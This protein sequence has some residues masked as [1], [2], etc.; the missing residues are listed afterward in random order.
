VCSSD[1]HDLPFV[2]RRFLAS[3]V[4]PD[5]WRVATDYQRLQRNTHFVLYI[6]RAK[7]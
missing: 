5:W 1:L 6:L 2:D 4:S 7:R 3:S